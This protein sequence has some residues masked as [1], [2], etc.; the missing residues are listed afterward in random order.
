MEMES[1]V[2]NHPLKKKLNRVLELKLGENEELINGLISL[3]TV[4]D[5]SE[6]I[7]KQL[8]M[9]LLDTKGQ[10]K[11]RSMHFSIY[12]YHLMITENC[13]D[14]LRPF[15]EDLRAMNNEIKA[16][17]KEFN[18]SI[19]TQLTN[20]HKFT[21]PLLE[22]FKKIQDQIQIVENKRSM[23]NTMLSHLSTNF[24][25]DIKNLKSS[26]DESKG[27]LLLSLVAIYNKCMV[28]ETN[29]KR[30]IEIFSSDSQKEESTSESVLSK[31]KNDPEYS[32]MIPKI[33][34][35]MKALILDLELKRNQLASE[36]TSFLIDQ[37]IS[38]SPDEFNDQFEL[39]QNTEDEVDGM[40]KGAEGKV[41]IFGSQSFQEAVEIL[42]LYHEE[43]CCSLLSCV[44]E[45]R[46]KY[47]EYRF[48]HIIE[49]G[50]SI[51]D[52]NYS[53]NLLDY[54]ESIFEWIRVCGVSIESEFLV[55]AFGYEVCQ[56]C[57]FEEKHLD[58]N[59]N[60]TSGPNSVDEMANNILNSITHT[61]CIPF[62]GAIRDILRQFHPPRTS[63]PDSAHHFGNLTFLKTGITIGIKIAHLIDNYIETLIPLFKVL[64]KRSSSSPKQV[65]LA[66]PLLIQ[67]FKDLR[68]EAIAQYYV[69]A[70]IVKENVSSRISEIL[71]VDFSISLL[72]MEW[73][74][75]LRDILSTIQSGI[76]VI[77]NDNT[78]NREDINS[79]LTSMLETFINPMFNAICSVATSDETP[80]ASI[81]RINNI[82]YC[83]SVLTA[84]PKMNF[85]LKNQIEIADQII[86]DEVSKLTNLLKEEFCDKYRFEELLKELEVK[87]KSLSNSQI[88]D[89]SSDNLNSK[90]NSNYINNESEPGQDP[91]LILSQVI[92]DQF[93]ESI[94]RFG[95]IPFANA[96]RIQ[97]KQIR[98]SL[99][100]N[101][102]EHISRQ[103]E[104]IFDQINLIW[105]QESSFLKHD[106]HQIKLIFSNLTN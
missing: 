47:L 16:F 18:E 88:V 19:T 99:L 68:E 61:L 34:I 31:L 96:D 74:S 13:L 35:N 89:E 29:S 102:F 46:S 14:S 56:D 81:I 60:K 50:I 65:R 106:P 41:C 94:L 59:Q 67:R 103:Y 7:P 11:C 45:T 90:S 48:N 63:R 36:I 53:T 23:C 98:N 72:V 49:H 6:G 84:Y 105:P 9:E 76:L 52:A 28:S 91:L 21:F 1:S 15:V 4:D 5:V 17:E 3:D 93:F 100:K 22:E 24:V 42:R 54:L 83:L 80:L 82:S 64:P 87:K 71:T 86:N 38:K 75:L 32:N 20:W 57:E 104:L 78:P 70:G 97:D 30:L 79:I 25:G 101:L 37:V 39:S 40:E 55:K 43:Q 10:N 92:I 33:L 77:S 8:V 66:F 58:F 44:I 27:N 95:A 73:S 85:L 2:L 69:Y 26:M 62:S 51:G 12:K